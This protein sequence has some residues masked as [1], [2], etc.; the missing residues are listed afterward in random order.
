MCPQVTALLGVQL[1]EMS[2]RDTLNL[3]LPR[4]SD[5]FSSKSQTIKAPQLD[6]STWPIKWAD[7]PK[8][9]LPD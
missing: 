4:A 9:A 2:R 6:S 1:G 8:M 3:L 7:L 5:G